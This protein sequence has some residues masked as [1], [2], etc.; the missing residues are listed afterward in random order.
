MFDYKKAY[1]HLFTHAAISV[2]PKDSL[3]LVR[4]RPPKNATV[5]RKICNSLQ[6][7]ANAN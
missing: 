5:E 2:L 1:K 4:V 3:N 6:I 7:T